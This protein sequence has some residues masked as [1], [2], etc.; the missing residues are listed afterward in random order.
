[1]MS[2]WIYDQFNKCVSLQLLLS[3]QS[4]ERCFPIPL[5]TIQFTSGDFLDTYTYIY[6]IQPLCIDDEFLNNSNVK[7]FQPLFFFHRSHL[8][9]IL[10]AR[11]K[12]SAQSSKKETC[13][14]YYCARN[15][16]STN[17]CAAVVPNEEIVRDFQCGDEGIKPQDNIITPCT[18]LHH[19]HHNTIQ[20]GYCRESPD[21]PLRQF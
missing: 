18:S 21:S 14:P 4:T 9:K 6:E 16:V 17:I 20:K 11:A 5:H 12:S 8:G 2:K 10:S 3:I 1:M 15:I 19:I 7:G 13:L